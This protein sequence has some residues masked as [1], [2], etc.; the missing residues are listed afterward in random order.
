MN[1]TT[2]YIQDCTKARKEAEQA[3]RY[4]INRL[5]SVTG[6]SVVGIALT[7]RLYDDDVGVALDVR[8]R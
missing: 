1:D 8:L 5:E 4:A 7:E 6:L 3:I 2:I